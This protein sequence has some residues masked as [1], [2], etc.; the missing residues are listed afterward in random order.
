MINEVRVE[1]EA[2]LNVAQPA[3]LEQITGNYYTLKTRE[4][5]QN[6]LE[7]ESEEEETEWVEMDD[8]VPYS[9]A[10]PKNLIAINIGVVFMLVLICIGFIA[11]DSPEEEL[12]LSTLSPT[13]CL[14]L[15]VLN[16]LVGSLLTASGYCLQKWAHN[17]AKVN[18][19]LRPATRQPIFIGGLV[20]LVIGT[21]SPVL[22]LGLLG[23]TVQ[24]PFTALTLIY[25]AL[26]AKF[27][28][29]EEYSR[30]D[31]YSSLLIVGG[32]VIAVIG[33][34]LSNVVATNYDL[35]KL[36]HLFIYDSMLPPVYTVL[37][38]I[39]VICINRRVRAKKLEENAFGLFSFSF[40]AGVMSGFSSL[41]VKSVVE[42]AK[43]VVVRKSGDMV[44]PMTYVFMLLIPC[45]LV[46]QLMYM[47]NG[48][49]HFGTLKF[50]PLYAAFI[51][52]ANMASGQVYFNE[53]TEYTIISKIIFLVGCCITLLGV[54]IL[55]A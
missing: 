5:D 18:V 34:G 44:R 17:Q 20:L 49:K 13:S 24:A 4:Y 51:I 26:L 12:S 46:P 28:L 52:L 9:T 55:L 21:I 7:D 25:N 54:G 23:Q 3:E 36:L 8:S 11:F 41:A 32:V 29:K 30:Y 42:I 31:F 6:G 33:A 35:E 10:W 19:Y 39:T 50:V 53:M 37:A 15:G 27:I 45:S 47:N 43:S 40:S 14:I 38:I 22:N 1:E 48:L 16:S 2:S